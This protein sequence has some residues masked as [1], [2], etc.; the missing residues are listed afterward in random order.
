[1]KD[2]INYLGAT[3]IGWLMVYG[4]PVAIG[5]TLALIFSNFIHIKI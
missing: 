3:I 4:L 2:E 1:M 5:L